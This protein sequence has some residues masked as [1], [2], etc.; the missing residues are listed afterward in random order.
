MRC[1][2]VCPS[3]RCPPAPD[4]RATAA[5]I[6]TPSVSSRLA[7]GPLP[8]A[9]SDTGSPTKL[10]TIAAPT[11]PAALTT[12]LALTAPDWI[13]RAPEAAEREARVAGADRE[14]PAAVVLNGSAATK[15][16]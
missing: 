4:I 14:P 11:L 16:G 8:A 3:R 6:Y 13:I 1:R 12:E 7:T 2:G 9:P 5:F 10:L 15:A